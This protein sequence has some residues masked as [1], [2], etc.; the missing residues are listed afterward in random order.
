MNKFFLAIKTH[1]YKERLE[2]VFMRVSLKE[3]I[4]LIKQLAVLMKA[5]TP[6]FTALGMVKEQSRS[7][8]V[9]K[10]VAQVTHDVENGHSLASSLAK[11]KK[12]FG[13]L[14]INI[15]AVGEVS[16]NLSSNLE[17]LAITLKKKQALRRKVV[18][19]SIY[20]IFIIIAT[21]A[22][23]IL[24]TVFV[25]PKIIPVFKSINYQLPWSTRFLIWINNVTQA[26]GLVIAGCVIAVIVAI[27]LLLQVKKIRLWYD[28]GLLYVPFFNT[29]VRTYN[30]TSICRT[31]GLLLNS[32]TTVVRA[33]H[34]ASDTTKNLAYKK[35]LMAIS[36]N[37]TKG[38][39]ISANLQKNK[40]LFPIVVPQM[41]AVAES[42]GR[43]SETFSYLADVYE[44]DMDELTRNLSTTLEPILLIF[45]GIL[46]GF[47][48]ISIITPI[49]GITQHL[50]PK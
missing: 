25:F 3:Q 42:T 4:Q 14:T 23:T 19:A 38:E 27:G 29:M 26:H 16:G 32:G 15:I 39:I 5:G 10:I 47:I 18:G 35:V 44:E 45:M 20:P 46:V 13:E 22:I 30:T 28:A 37:I 17:H 50:T 6:L 43:L 34:I 8:S 2:K 48:A 11:F 9:K 36:E 33:F 40:R 1:P 24:L 21:L 12:I 49:Y 41:I 31:L 7:R